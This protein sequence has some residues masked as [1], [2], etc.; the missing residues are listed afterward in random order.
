MKVTCDICKKEV[1]PF[2]DLTIEQGFRY[3]IDVW[4]GVEQRDVD[5]C[6]SCYIDLHDSFKDWIKQRRH[7]IDQLEQLQNITKSHGCGE[8]EGEEG[9]CNTCEYKHSTSEC[10]GCSIY[11]ECD[12][13]ITHSKY[14]KK[15]EETE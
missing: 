4:D 3:A 7:H 13:L 8:S 14:K 12:N 10:I 11:D 15:S 9:W 2:N 5:I 6:E 1:K